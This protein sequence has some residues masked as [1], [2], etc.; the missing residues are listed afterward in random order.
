[1]QQKPDDIGRNLLI[2]MDDMP[3]SI[4]MVRIV[5]HQLPNPSEVKVT[6]MHY[7][8]PIFWEYD[9]SPSP[10]KQEAIHKEIDKFWKEERELHARTMSYFDRAK[11]ILQ[12]VGV[13]ADQIETRIYL[14]ENFARDAILDELK[15]GAYSTVVVGG[16]HNHSLFHILDSS[17]AGYIQRHARDIQ[18]WIVEAPQIVSPADAAD[19]ESPVFKLQSFG[20]SV[21]L[22]Y[23]RRGMLNSGELWHLI[24]EEGLKGV[25]SNPSIFEKAIAGSTDYD[26]TISRMAHEGKDVEEISQALMLQDVKHA[27]DLLHPV[28]RQTG[29]RDGF[30]SIEVSPL[31]AHEPKGTV[32]E[33]RRLWDELYR[34]NIMIKV[35]GTREGLPAIQ[36]LI[37][38]GINVNVTLLFSLKRYAEVVDA[39]LSGLEERLTAGKDIEDI[40]SVASFFLSRI[41]VITDP[42]LERIIKEGG[43]HAKLAE[44]LHGEIA[45]A[46]AKAAYKIYQELFNSERFQALSSRGAHTQRL[47]WASTSTKN[48]AYSDVKYVE[49]LIGSNTVTTIPIETL[50]AYRDHGQPKARL[51]EGLDEAEKKL[52]SL[53]E[54]G[55]DL[56][57]L[58][59]QLEDEGVQKFAK[60]YG[61]LHRVLEKKVARAHGELLNPQSMELVG[62]EQAVRDRLSQF[63]KEEISS[64]IWA[65]DP[66]CWKANRAE[67][68]MI[69]NS[70]GWL[71][72]AEKM[73]ANLGSIQK[74]AS[75]LKEQGFTHVVHLGMG[76]SS[77]TALL[78][79]KVFPK[80]KDGLPLTVLDT[81]DPATVL[82]V[83]RE[84]EI[85][86]TLFIVASKSGTTTEPL[87]LGDYFYGKLKER[88]G[89]QAGDNFIAITDPETPLV[90]LAHE[91]GFRHV[92]INFKDIGGRYSALSYFGLVPAVLMGLDVQ[93]LLDRTLR[94]VQACESSIPAEDNPAL[95]LGAALGEL[96]FKG[97]DKV[98]LLAP[99]QLTPFGMWLEQLLAESTG[100]EGTG[101]LPVV[102]E[103]PDNLL[104]YGR[105]R[106]FVYL[107]YLPQKD[108]DLDRVVESIRDHGHPIITIEINDLLSLGQEF[109]RWEMA[110]ATVGIILGINP[111]DQP[112]VQESKDNA[113]HLLKTLVE[114]GLLINEES[115]VDEDGLSYYGIETGHSFAECLDRFLGQA[116]EGDYIALQAYFPEE[117]ET[118]KILQAIRH[119]MRDVFHVATT[120]GYGPRF[121]HSTGQYHKGGPNRGLFVQLTGDDLEDE[122]IPE[123]GYTLGQIKHA[124]ALGDM[125]ALRKHGRRVIRI[126]LGEDVLAGL[127]TLL[128]KLET[129]VPIAGN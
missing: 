67:T 92:F 27:A 6:L 46:S 129:G 108:M 55:I 63:Q 43:S 77:L 53:A 61:A 109:F 74:F 123:R 64:R 99:E 83:E 19:M 15:R 97:R 121:L 96:A 72:V 11:I 70:L 78:F 100:K 1:M 94:M 31:L 79:E 69:K 57:E 25:T 29:G 124:K 36:Q 45:M 5:A 85:E 4:A 3:E 110:T 62:A 33:A 80:G 13:L 105:D 91:R 119:H 101:L 59:Q 114:Q 81:V 107:R 84:I 104:A 22:D 82:K 28:Y 125:Q 126:H 7:I 34:P 103:K 54:L 48:P 95:V 50:I 115:V 128:S 14:D 20:Q 26:E 38:E 65:K 68:T 18:V 122:Y 12:D 71:H 113:K 88:L 24:L 23:I 49:A 42:L 73:E 21:W 32:K 112:N 10:E 75:E 66:T 118:E 90:D 39:Y 40:A 87:A 117:P 51:T 86:K 37:R 16:H 2:A 60:A 102:G 47:L 17:I 44:S 56:D 116:R 111:F 76:G 89:E 41:D 30:V 58:T 127:S 8:A 106:V 93:S 35:P 120:V 52:K 98:T 9:A